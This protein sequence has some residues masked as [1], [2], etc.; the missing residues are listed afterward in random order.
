MN[1]QS[2]NREEI[3]RQL[4]ELQHENN[5]LR[6]TH[7]Q[8]ILD[9]RQSLDAWREGHMLFKAIFDDSPFGVAIVDSIT[10]RIFEVNP[11]FAKIAGRSME[12]MRNIDWISITHPDDIQPDLDKMALLVKGVINGFRM[13]KRYF[14]PDGSIVWI[15]MTISK[16][17]SHDD[18]SLHHLCMIEDITER[19]QKE[20]LVRKLSE[21]VQQSPISIVITNLDGCIEYANPKTCE[22]TGYTLNELLGENPRILKSGET[23]SEEYQHLWDSITHGNTWKGVFH[24]KR[25]NG[26][27]Y[28][29]F[30]RIAPIVDGQGRT[31]SYLAIKEDI[32]ERRK[33]EEALQSKTT[34]LEAQINATSEGILVVDE[35]GKKNL[36]NQRFIELFDLPQDI[37]VE[38]EALAILNYGALQTKYPDQFINKVMYL[39]D[40]SDEVSKDEI[41]FGNGMVLESFSAPILGKDERNYGRIWTFRDT[42]EQKKAEQEITLKNKELQKANAEKDKFFSIIAHDL[43]SPFSGLLGLTDLM[44][45]ESE[46]M[47]A[48][49]MKELSRYL[50]ISAHNTFNLLEDLLEWAKM[51]RGLIEFKPQKIS[52]KNAVTESLYLLGE[53]ARKKLID[54]VTDI[55]NQE[56]YAD[57]H[58]LQTVLRN[59]TSNAIKYTNKGGKVTISCSGSDNNN[60]LILVK[61]SGIGMSAYIRDNIFKIGA[62]TKRIGTQG[63]HSSGLG[64]LLCKEFVEKQGGEIWV[65]SEEGFG[66]A[67]Y[68]TVPLLT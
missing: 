33:T 7:N 10:G 12:E 65:E 55:Q 56:V 68:F 44:S 36:M 52:L 66:S 34:L 16:L 59:L 5:S 57:S 1:Y 61:D 23:P 42:T 8:E 54:L 46:E 47:S 29:E 49:E 67:F 11:M 51:E 43:R 18:I 19:K 24:N 48:E 35:D 31:I 53:S 30:A 63:E 20:E 45:D 21:A 22:T 58:M 13:E 38:N 50:N 64:L 14:H 32:T 25:K 28:W 41:E 6:A 37:V 26:E 60:L 15:N 4:L 3:I 2:T 39:F 27:Y 9:L 40:H 17:I 62:N